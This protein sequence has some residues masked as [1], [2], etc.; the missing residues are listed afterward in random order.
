MNKYAV[1]GVLAFAFGV[2]AI[3]Q[4]ALEFPKSWAKAA[5]KSLSGADVAEKPEIIVPAPKTAE[6]PAGL[7]TYV[8]KQP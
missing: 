8:P 7:Q 4:T 6:N 2:A 3:T 1:G 5:T